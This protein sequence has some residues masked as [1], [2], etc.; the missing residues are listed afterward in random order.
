LR[1]LFAAEQ[2]LNPVMSDGTCLKAK[3]ERRKGL[4]PG[5]EVTVCGF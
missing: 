3:V 4:K 2:P 5:D 1:P